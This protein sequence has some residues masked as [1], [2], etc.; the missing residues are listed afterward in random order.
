VGPLLLL[1]RRG[2][3]P[4]RLGAPHRTPTSPAGAGPVGQTRPITWLW[5]AAWP[6]GRN[7]AGAS[8]PP[9]VEVTATLRGKPLLRSRH[10]HRSRWDGRLS[11]GAPLAANGGCAGHIGIAFRSARIP[12][13]AMY[14]KYA[15]LTDA[16]HHGTVWAEVMRWAPCCTGGAAACSGRGFGR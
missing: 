7:L 5:A 16:S 15:N 4:A 9:P 2:T 6:S 10:N 11:I 3:G 14:G 8:W 1:P 12:P 13:W